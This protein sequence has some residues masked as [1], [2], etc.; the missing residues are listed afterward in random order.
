MDYR[1]QT[2]E[3]LILQVLH[4]ICSWAPFSVNCPVPAKGTFVRAR[5]LSHPV[6]LLLTRY[7][8]KG[9]KF[10]YMHDLRQSSFRLGLSCISSTVLT[11]EGW[12]RYW[13][14]LFDLCM[15][16]AEAPLVVPSEITKEI[17]FR[18][19]CSAPQ[20]N[21]VL[22]ITVEMGLL[23]WGR[24]KISSLENADDVASFSLSSKQGT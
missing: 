19:G 1:E 15:W 18:H 4:S 6:G 20:F 24:R 22:E 23:S 5:P 17:D 9:H 11:K 12:I 2:T 13:F 7:A 21:F 8:E 10:S 16:E 14:H 3:E